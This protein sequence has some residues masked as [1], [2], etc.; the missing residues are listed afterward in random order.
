MARLALFFGVQTTRA[1]QDVINGSLLEI[2]VITSST[3]DDQSILHTFPPVALF[4]V[5]DTLNYGDLAHS[6]YLATDA[7]VAI[8]LLVLVLLVVPLEE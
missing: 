6:S 2:S 5:A 4:S 8:V 7:V 3:P 1:C